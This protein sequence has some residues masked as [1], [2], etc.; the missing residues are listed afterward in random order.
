MATHSRKDERPTTVAGTR[1][2]V[3]ALRKKT[4]LPGA[5]RSAFISL[6][7]VLLKAKEVKPKISNLQGA[8]LPNLGPQHARSHANTTIGHQNA[9]LRPL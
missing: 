6:P 5:K 7:C 8:L 3:V 4:L 2:P 9:M 1:S